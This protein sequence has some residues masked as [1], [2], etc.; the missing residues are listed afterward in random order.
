M[1]WPPDL[2]GLTLS[3]DMYGLLWNDIA[4]LDNRESNL[5]LKLK[6]LTIRHCS[7][8]VSATNTL[9]EHVGP[10][11]KYLQVT[12]MTHFPSNRPGPLND[13]LRLCPKLEKLVI[14]HNYLADNIFINDP[15]ADT[16]YPWTKTHPLKH[17]ELVEFG[18]DGIDEHLDAL[19]FHIALTDGAMQ[20]LRKIVVR[21]GI[22]G[23][24]LKSPSVEW[25]G[26][27]SL[28]QEMARDEGGD[29]DGAGVFFYEAIR[30]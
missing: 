20:G 18:V 21:N 3:G 4:P 14:A 2:E 12:D 19:D 24:G 29:V 9:I 11:L 13:V 30:V 17:F 15:T 22:G 8:N 26:I 5:P 16:C 27:S 25:R 28:L 10:Q 1:D 7:L 23:R 6:S